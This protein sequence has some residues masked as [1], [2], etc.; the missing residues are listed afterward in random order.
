ML[1][2]YF[3]IG[4]FVCHVDCYDRET[5]LW[6]YR[7][8]EVPVLNG[9]TCEKFIEMNKI[10]S[11]Q[12]ESWCDI[13]DKKF[14]D[15]I[16]KYYEMGKTELPDPTGLVTKDSIITFVRGAVQWEASRTDDPTP[17][18]LWMEK[19]EKMFQEL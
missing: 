6:G 8:D 18:I 5:G 9:W 13:M 19:L 10:C 11:W 2:T 7:C 17:V 3:K 1:N 14:V 16:M 15:F 12:I 4:D